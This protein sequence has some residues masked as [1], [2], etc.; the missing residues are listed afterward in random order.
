MPLVDPRLAG[1][2]VPKIS[3]EAMERGHVAR[4]AQARGAAA[5]VVSD[6]LDELRNCQRVLVVFKGSIVKAFGAGWS[7]RDLIAAIEGVDA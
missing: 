6:E 5:L 1:Q 3:R 4:A 2:P 7:E